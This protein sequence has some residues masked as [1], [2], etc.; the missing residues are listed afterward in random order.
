M[1]TDPQLIREIVSRPDVFQKKRPDPIGE[2]VTGGLLYLEDEKWAKHRRIVAPAFHADRLKGMA[3]AMRLS[4]LIMVE[5]W[6]ALFGDGPMEIDVW[7]WLQDLAGDVISR[8]AFGSSHHEGRRIFELQSE[9]VKLVLEILQFIF[10]PGW[11][12]VPTKTNRRVKTISKEIRT[13]L[14]GIISRR[15]KAMQKGEPVGEDLLGMLMESNFGSKIQGHKNKKTG[16]SIEDVI[17]ECNLF[18][19][20]GSETTSSLLVW[21][22]VM[23]SVHQEWQ[24][25]ARE[26]VVQVFGTNEPTTF[27]GLSCL[28][29]VTMI[30]YEVMRLYAPVPVIARAPTKAVELGNMRI[31]AGLD[32]ILV[33]GLL[34]NDPKIWGDDANEFKPDRLT[35][36]SRFAF[37]PFSSGPRVCIGHHYAMVEVKTALAMILQRFRFELS[38]NYLH[39]PFSILTLQPQN[40][41]SLLLHKL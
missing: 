31:P 8:T 36:K 29:I 35:S 14:R 39:A 34:H 20:A 1:I 22:M 11:R 4:C 23:L 38:P 10:I 41:A 26:E 32:L 12:Y 28:K 24:D 6:Q 9:L 2:T 15:E 27:D 21:T 3:P 40:G 13:L 30:L 18:Y 5:K 17:E 25:R 7:P 37:M 33:I 16:L 19:F